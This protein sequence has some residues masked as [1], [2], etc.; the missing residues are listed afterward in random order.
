[1]RQP[2]SLAAGENGKP[3]ARMGRRPMEP[4]EAITFPV[5]AESADVVDV[6]RTEVE[7]GGPR[8]TCGHGGQ[9]ESGQR[10]DDEDGEVHGAER[11]PAAAR[12]RRR[13]AYVVTSTAA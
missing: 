6:V 10:E 4:R 1:H 5:L 13:A 12:R 2:V 11:R 8:V 7:D 9:D 3:H